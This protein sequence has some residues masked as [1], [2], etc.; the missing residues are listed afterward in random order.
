MVFIDC[1]RTFV[2]NKDAG[3]CCTDCLQGNL[4]KSTIQWILVSMSLPQLTPF[5]R[6][7]LDVSGSR[8]RS[9]TRT[10]FVPVFRALNF[11]GIGVVMGHE[12]THAFDDQGESGFDCSR[13]FCDAFTALSVQIFYSSILD[14]HSEDQ[15]EMIEETVIPERL[16]YFIVFYIYL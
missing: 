9:L 8:N 13:W 15:I 1:P 7:Q 4:F 12:L 10:V 16:L 14:P 6:C 2:F 3:T 11:G 5:V